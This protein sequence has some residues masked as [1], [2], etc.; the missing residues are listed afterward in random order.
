M[1]GHKNLIRN[2]E[3]GNSVRLATS[4]CL[5]GLLDYAPFAEE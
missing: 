1:Y 5:P 2:E 4:V 3:F